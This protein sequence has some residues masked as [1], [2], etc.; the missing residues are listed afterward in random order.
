MSNHSVS[1]NSFIP[2]CCC[3][4]LQKGFTPLH[5]AA[6]YGKMEVANLLLQKNAPPDAAGKVNM[7]NRFCAPEMECLLRRNYEEQRPVSQSDQSSVSVLSREER[8]AS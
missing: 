6:K 1:Y 8:A 3:V 4:C 7:F 2:P 5:V